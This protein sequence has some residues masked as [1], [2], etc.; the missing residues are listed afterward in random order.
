MK[1]I[2]VYALMLLMALTTIT[3]TSSCSRGYGCNNLAGEERANKKSRPNKKSRGELFD[4][5]TRRQLSGQ[6]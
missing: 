3:T 1:R 4:R 5:R 6:E 2:S